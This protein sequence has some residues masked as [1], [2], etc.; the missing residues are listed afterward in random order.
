MVVGQGL[1]VLSL[2]AHQGGP[3]EGHVVSDGQLGHGLVHQLVLGRHLPVHVAGQWG[4]QWDCRTSSEAQPPPAL[5]KVPVAP[6]NAQSWLSSGVRA[7]SSFPDW[8][9]P[10]GGGLRTPGP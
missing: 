9:C 7:P 8:C 6:R 4:I 5:T 2:D 3:G 1:E 10:S